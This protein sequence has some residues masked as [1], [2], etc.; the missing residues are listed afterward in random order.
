MASLKVFLKSGHPWTL[1]CSFLYFDFCFAVWV[2]NGA[3]APFIS[4]TFNLTP[5]EKGFMLSVP[6]ISGALM[7]FPLGVLSQY[8]G[9]K[10][11]ALVEMGVI[12]LGL[13]WGF[14]FVKS[15]TDVLLMGIP[16]G[17]AGASF[18]VALSLGGG[19]FP[20]QYKGLAIGIAGAGNSG[21]VLAVLFAPPLAIRYGWQNVYGFAV[22]LMLLP[23]LLMLIFAKE[24]PDREKKTFGENMKVLVEKDAWVFNI[25]YILTF[26]GYIGFTNFLPTLFHDG[27]G[28]SKAMMGQLAAPIIVMASITRIIGGWIADRIGGLNVMITICVAVCV[29]SLIATTLPPIIFM[30]AIM[31]LLFCA[32]GAGNGSTFQL[33]PHRWPV[34]TAIAMSLIGEIGALGGGLIPNAMGL[35]KQYYGTFSY[36]FLLWAGIAGVIFIMYL[37]VQRRWTTS[38]VGKGGRALQSAAKGLK[39]QTA[40]EYERLQREGKHYGV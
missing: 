4:E 5:A 12:I 20:P 8:I 24:P 9:R 39:I 1:F 23:F 14:F 3:M 22:A 10:S 27:Y 37:K 6:I 34:T 29:I 40:D 2:L 18:G 36:G 21:A 30:M 7:R 25:S 33:V 26:G 16:L 13:G 38:W 11:A 19:W 32:L 31:F 35:S 17:I 15:Y 28:I